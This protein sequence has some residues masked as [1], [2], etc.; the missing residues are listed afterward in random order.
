MDVVGTAHLYDGLVGRRNDEDSRGVRSKLVVRTLEAHRRDISLVEPVQVT[1]GTAHVHVEVEVG[2]VA[3]VVGDAELEATGRSRSIRIGRGIGIPVDGL[4]HHRDGRTVTRIVEEL[5]DGRTHVVEDDVVVAGDAGGGEGDVTT[6][7]LTEH[8]NLVGGHAVRVA[9]LGNGLPEVTD[10]RAAVLHTAIGG[11]DQLEGPLGLRGSRRV[12]TETVI[13]AGDHV[14]L[15][16][17]FGTEGHRTGV[18]A[19]SDCASV[20]VLRQEVSGVEVEDERAIRLGITSRLI[21]VAEQILRTGRQALQSGDDRDVVSVHHTGRDLHLG[22]HLIDVAH[23]LAVDLAFG[24]RTE[25]K[26]HPRGVVIHDLVNPE[27]GLCLAHGGVQ[28]KL[29]GQNVG[30]IG[31]IIGLN[32][33]LA[34]PLPGAAVEGL[35]RSAIHI[36]VEDREKTVPPVVH[37]SVGVLDVGIGEDRVVVGGI[38]IDLLMDV[39]STAHLHDGLIG[40][41]DDEH[42]RLVGSERVVRALDT[43]HRDVSLIEPVEVAQGT[44]E[45]D[46][47]VEVGVVTDV[48]RHAELETTGRGRSVSIGRGIRVTVDGLD[49]HRNGRTVARIVEELRDGHAHVVEDD[50]VVVGDA[51]RSERDVSTRSFS[52]E[53]DLR[54]VD[55]VRI[56]VLGHRLPEEAD[57][58]AAVLDSAVSSLNQLKGPLSL[59]G[60]SRVP[61]EA[62]V[63]TGHHIAHLGVAGADFD[64]RAVGLG[65]Q[66]SAV[67]VGRQEV[68]GVEVQQQRT[69]G[70]GVTGGFVEVE[71]ERLGCGREALQR[72]DDRD[73]GSVL[74]VGSDGDVAEHLVEVTRLSTGSQAD[75]EGR[76]QETGLLHGLVHRLNG[77][78]SQ[79]AVMRVLITHALRRR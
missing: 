68:S 42:R 25:G 13:T 21:D 49:H 39:V 26:A 11:L 8:G 16:G 36:A 31:I 50:V 22:E 4:N 23:T 12:P 51:G 64:G 60:R 20:H 53:T 44:S 65:S 6:G 79:R 62:I 55:S 54:G 9:V 10:G 67:D 77:Q 61:A 40:R 69:V 45:V 29:R 75:G 47:E 66:R 14:S 41:R 72:G 74:N 38:A 30:A 76:Q 43:D 7:S 15:L 34:P 71:H 37:G 35:G 33:I 59:R 1:E 3:H 46:L 48:V 63:D 17:E 57:G 73:V 52:D 70:L 18:R 24:Q 27:H 2:A 56:T 5:G 28:R 19:V 32:S 78:D 58:R